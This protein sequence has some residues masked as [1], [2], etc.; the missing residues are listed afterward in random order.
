MYGEKV[1]EEI[2]RGEAGFDPIVGVA[3]ASDNGPWRGEEGR[4]GGKMGK[5][6]KK[7]HR[8]GGRKE[9]GRGRRDERRERG[10]MRR[11]KRKICVCVPRRIVTCWSK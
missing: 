3:S 7:R 2:G 6:D 10:R 8:G 5:T 1:G 9:E 4:K 11:E